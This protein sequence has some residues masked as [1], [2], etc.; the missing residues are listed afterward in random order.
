MKIVIATGNSHKVLEL[1]ALF[2]KYNTQNH[3]FVS[4]KEAGF[5]GEIIED[6]DTFEGNALIKARAV[7]KAT[8]CIAIADDSGLCVDALNG[9][10]GIYSARYAGD[11]ATDDANNKKLL[12]K[13]ENVPLK[14]R[15]ARFCCVIAGVFPDGK[16]VVARG[17]CE[18]IIGLQKQGKGDFGYD[19][20]FYYEPFGK[21]F[22]E[23]TDSEKNSVSHRGRA[24]ENFAREFFGVLTK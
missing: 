1:S 6:A 14:K 4:M 19:P 10:P 18:G 17:E 22:A 11:G 3:T 12:E 8:G 9:E 13:L 15:T 16:E 23:M 20:L 21:T 5:S 24:V 7:C 2:G